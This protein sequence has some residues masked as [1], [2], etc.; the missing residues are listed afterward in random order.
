MITGEFTRIQ[1]WEFDFDSTAFHSNILCRV[2]ILIPFDLL[3]IIQNLPIK[4]PFSLN[5]GIH[6]SAGPRARQP[7]LKLQ[8]VLQGGNG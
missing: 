3:V 5:R 6:V 1:A 4:R 7:C 8:L 2:H